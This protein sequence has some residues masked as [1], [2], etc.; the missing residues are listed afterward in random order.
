MSSLWDSPVILVYS[1]DMGHWIRFT[2][3][4]IGLSFFACSQAYAQVGRCWAPKTDMRFS[5][6]VEQTQYNTS[7]SAFAL[8]H[9]TGG[10]AGGG[11][12]LGLAY[13]PLYYT[14][15]ALFRVSQ[16]EK[17]YCV[18]FDKMKMLWRAQPFVLISEEFPRGSCEFNAVLVHENKHVRAL[19][20]VHARHAASFRQHVEDSLERVRVIGPVSKNQ[21][22]AAQEKLSSDFKVLLD[23]Y[24]VN[25]RNELDKEQ[26]KVDSPSE[27][28]RVSA[29]CDDW[30]GR[31]RL[32]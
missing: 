32:E 26:T 30:N 16:N 13:D 8:N 9:M 31:L 25:V 4:L 17:G 2:V 27:Y 5:P 14:Y 6:Q 22:M 19:K 21:I 18:S 7:Q 29:E 15:E 1:N 3:V 28:E 23:E 24:L 12:V 10:P 11:L 20:R